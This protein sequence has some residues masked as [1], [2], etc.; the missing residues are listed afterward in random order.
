[1]AVVRAVEFE[2]QK[3][4]SLSGVDN[5]RKG[6][7]DEPIIELVEFINGCEDLFTTSSC[8]G[9]VAVIS[10]VRPNFDLL[11]FFIGHWSISPDSSYTIYQ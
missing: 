10:Q 1:M 7:V 3:S 2:R 8:S 9:R 11:S 4:K 6:S 5:S